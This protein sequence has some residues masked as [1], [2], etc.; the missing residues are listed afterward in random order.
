[1][2]IR[3]AH[4]GLD[5]LVLFFKRD[6]RRFNS[7]PDHLEAI[8][9]CIVVA[10]QVKLTCCWLGEIPDFDCARVEF[11][12]PFGDGVVCNQN[13]I[14]ATRPGESGWLQGAPSCFD[15]NSPTRCGFANHGAWIFPIERAHPDD[16][17]QPLV[18]SND[19]AV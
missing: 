2:G 12:I 17:H 3:P 4:R 13:L 1:M 9:G 19:K 6:V 8:D 11:A 5:E 15:G 14:Q 7:T 16:S 18:I 10:V